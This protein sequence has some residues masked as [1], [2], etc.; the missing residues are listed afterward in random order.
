MFGTYVGEAMLGI[1]DLAINTT[2]FGE[3]MA[4]FGFIMVHCALEISVFLSFNIQSGE[5]ICA[6][7][8][9]N[10]F[11]CWRRYLAV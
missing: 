4:N 11:F 8:V 9:S 6:G 7:D 1:K 3:V 5:Q 2:L 10:E